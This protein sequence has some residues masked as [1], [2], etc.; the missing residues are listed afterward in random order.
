MAAYKAVQ[1]SREVSN[2]HMNPSH[3]KRPYK[4]R[5]QVGRVYKTRPKGTYRPRP[6]RVY[7]A[8]PNRVPSV[9]LPSLP[10]ERIYM[11]V[12]G[13]GI[14]YGGNRKDHRYTLLAAC[15]ETHIKNPRRYWVENP[16]GL[17]TKQCLDFLLE[18][19]R[20][21]RKLFAYA[22]N[23]D[24]TKILTDLDNLRLFLLFRPE[25]RKRSETNVRRNTSP[26]PV[27]WQGYILNLQGT[28]FT[29][30]RS[31]G[32]KV[33]LWDTWKF[34]QSKFTTALLD[35][36]V[37]DPEVI[38]RMQEMKAKRNAFILETPGAIREYC[39]SECQEMATLARKLDE[40]HKAAGLKLTAY[41]G[42]GSSASAM[43]KKMGIREK[44]RTV[45]HEMIVSVAQ[46]FFGG[47]FEHSVIGAIREPVVNWDISS[48]Y[49]YQLCFLP[50]QEHGQWRHTRR[51][52][53]LE[54]SRTALV[55]YGLDASVPCTDWAPFP[56]RTE[57]GSIC[58][59]RTSGGGWIW[60]D[61]Y[62]AGEAGWPNLVQFTEA[63]VYDSDC[64]CTPF[65]DIPH[66]Y[67]ERIRI[68]KEGAGIVFKLGPNSCYGK[69]AQSVGSA[70]FNSW[71]W[72][73]LITSGCRAQLLQMM[74]RA[75]DRRNVLMLATDG[76][77]T[78]EDYESIV[79]RDT[80]TWETK[81]PLGGWERKDYPKGVFAARPG[82]YFPLNPTEADLEKVR[83]RGIGRATLFQ[84]WQTIIAEYDRLSASGS[85]KAI[86]GQEFLLQN[87]D[88]FCGAK[89][90]IS[91]RKSDK[92]FVRAA[93]GREKDGRSLPAYGQWITRPV[94]MSFD[95]MPKRTGLVR[96]SQTRLALRTIS[97][98][99]ESVPYSKAIKSPENTELEVAQTEV[100]EQPDIDYYLSEDLTE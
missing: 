12:D 85:L 9:R 47:R 87:V 79:P 60:R 19:P 67:R 78:T 73:G 76:L 23:Y 20:G 21:D 64:T 30:A 42:A 26:R 74:C 52:K 55:R 2:G 15:T 70:P 40:A 33:T 59:P 80:G 57:D 99:F 58:F 50:C 32:K 51:R 49:P 93:G 75:K 84:Q 95:P 83:A 1:R 62:L 39:F 38:K 13:E 91:Y 72:A 63:W 46:A 66:Y 94:K 53:D 35:W 22:F 43:L 37:G 54:K 4:Y 18:L 29:L 8:R 28:K 31:G 77:Y 24:L 6:N 100:E 90:S 5:S 81:K 3:K 14:D 97:D 36:K 69:V 71:M 82:I 98:E 7:K 61:E 34:Y 65:K 44:I 25:L 41:Y 56:F 45:P 48:A 27:H 92:Q 96:G 89:T 16:E 17:S 11:G 68:G 88:R 10:R 86:K